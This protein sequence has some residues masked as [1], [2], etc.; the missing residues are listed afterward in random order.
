M[1]GVSFDLIKTTY[2]LEKLV[3]CVG[4]KNLRFLSVPPMEMTF[5]NNTNIIRHTGAAMGTA[6]HFRAECLYY[7]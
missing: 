5:K 4:K 1:F 7:K 3:V 6:H 2:H